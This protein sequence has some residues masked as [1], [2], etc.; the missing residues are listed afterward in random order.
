[1]A[2][3][4]K[5]DEESKLI[6][7]RI[8]E[9]MARHHLSSI[10][11]LGHCL[12]FVDEVDVKL[13]VAGELDLSLRLF[14]DVRALYDNFGWNDLESA[15][16]DRLDELPIPASRLEF[17]V[18]Y[19]ITGLAEQVAMGSYESS[20]CPEFAAIALKHLERAVSRPEPTRFVAYCEEES[21]RPQA[22]QFFDRWSQVARGSFGRLGSKTSARA[23]ELEIRKF[24]STE[25]N[26]RLTRLLQPL[27]I[28]CGLKLQ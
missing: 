6:L 25:M 14:S 8:M 26:E 10:N 24:S 7:R 21:H 28:Q 23:V 11:T 4:Q 27:A 18:A 16:R 22:Q 12:K 2:M 19:F 3:Q 20:S 15:V 1:M 5:L 13:V 9:S 17:G